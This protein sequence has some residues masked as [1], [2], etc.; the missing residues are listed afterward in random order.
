MEIL[1]KFGIDPVLLVAQ[2]INFGIILYVLKKFLYKPVMMMLK[3]RRD[4][5]Q[6]G[7]TDAEKAAKLLEEASE[8]EK[9]LLRNAQQEAKKLLSDARVQANDILDAAKQDTLKIV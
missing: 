4:E 8:K 9:K 7:L 3:T 6:K 1:D 5:I 2:F